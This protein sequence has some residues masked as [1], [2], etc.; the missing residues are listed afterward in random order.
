MAETPK[1][2]HRELA[3]VRDTFESIWIAIVLAFVLR[4][5][6]FEAFVIPTGSMAP[7]LLGEHWDLQCPDCKLAF[8][9]GVGKDAA[10]VI[11]GNK[12]VTVK[13][14]QCPNCRLSF[15]EKRYRSGGDRV[16]VLKYLY[17]FSPPKPWD[18]V[19]F[20]NPQDN[21]QNYIKRLVG[22]P[23]ETIEI[24]HGDVFVSDSPGGQRR[25]RT[26]PKRAQ[27]AMWQIVYDHDYL[28]SAE[29]KD[30]PRWRP[31]GGWASGESDERG[32]RFLGADPGELTF[33]APSGTF[34]PH[35][36]YNF[37]ESEE[38]HLDARWDVCSDL[39]LSFVLK[40]GAAKTA[41]TL[42]TSSFEEKFRA[43]LHTDGR[44]VLLQ[45]LPGEGWRLWG[46]EA[47]LSPL[48]TGKGVRVALTHVDFRVTLWV[49][50][51]A[52]LERTV[53][54]DPHA[55][56]WL[57]QRMT[58]V[59]ESPIPAPQLRIAASGGPCEL[60]HVRVMR[61]VY[62]TRA[63][64]QPPMDVDQPGPRAD[65]YKA[66]NRVDR[67]DPKQRRLL[68]DG[69]IRH[70]PVE[71]RQGGWGT[72]DRAISLKKHPAEDSE[73][74]EFFCLGD[75]SPQSL[76]GRGWILAAPTLR[77][78]AKDGKTF[79]YQLGTVP[80]Y[81]MTGKA[82]LVYWPSGFRIPGLPGLPIIPNVGKMRLIR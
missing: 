54:E 8:A 49:D 12:Q 42:E 50:G 26:K 44:A 62:Y 82:L 39:K 7:R 9:F 4:A 34:L 33:D 59:R 10:S 25:V 47:R 51:R 48:K 36:G 75:N 57:K 61:D 45:H 58:R 63:T 80:R 22:L 76:D 72:L 55:Y 77:L 21:R 37:R 19:V 16:F 38:E 11:P 18:V 28:P 40:P 67:D 17:H 56:E 79:Q 29:R 70:R 53:R 23:G 35:Y 65:Y 43:E 20:K 60:W 32:F 2:T 68:P 3:G 13:G 73:L 74:D 64:L 1:D 15:A 24:V 46:R 5:F 78:F 41:V 52:V 66:I 69:G 81:N 31:G 71:F 6:M 30:V 27:D 14:A